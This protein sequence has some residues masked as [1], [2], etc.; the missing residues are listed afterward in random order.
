MILKW[1]WVFSH[2]DFEA[3][4]WIPRIRRN[5]HDWEMREFCSMLNALVGVRPVMN[6][7]DRMVFSLPNPVIMC[8][9]IVLWRF[10]FLSKGFG[11]QVLLPGIASGLVDQ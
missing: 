3:N 1:N 10:I 4:V 7:R 9:L 11:I 8:F 2:F 5:L 6:R